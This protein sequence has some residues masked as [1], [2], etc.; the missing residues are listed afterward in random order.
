MKNKPPPP[1]KI[2]QSPFGSVA[3]I[4]LYVAVCI[5]IITMLSIAAITSKTRNNN[6]ELYPILPITIIKII[7]PRMIITT[8]YFL[9]LDK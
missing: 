2:K 1:R 8:F 7:H 5:Y 4:V 6:A 9:I 3:Y